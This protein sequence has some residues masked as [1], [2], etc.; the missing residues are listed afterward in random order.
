MQAAPIYAGNQRLFFLQQLGKC[1][2]PI[3][4][5]NQRIFYLQQMG[6]CEQTKL[7]ILQWLRTGH[8]RHTHKGKF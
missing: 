8:M 6:K 1:E 3:Y 2:Q 5:G 7:N 4:A